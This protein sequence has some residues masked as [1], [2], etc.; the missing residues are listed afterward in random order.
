MLRQL[1]LGVLSIA[2]CLAAQNNYVVDAAGGGDFTDLPAALAVAVHGD[3]VQVRP[4]TYTPASTDQGIRILGSSGARFATGILRIHAL[5]RNRTFALQDFAIDANS[6]V[7]LVLDD[8]LGPVHLE[9]LRSTGNSTGAGGLTLTVNRSLAVT[10]VSSGFA[11]GAPGIKV[12]G[13]A[14]HL[15]LIDCVATGRS[16]LGTYPY[17]SGAAGMEIWGGR[18]HCT[19]CRFFGGWASSIRGSGGHG[20]SIRGTM[21]L[22]LGPGCSGLG[23]FGGDSFYGGSNGQALCRC[24]SGSGGL[25]RCDPSNT[26]LAGS[27]TIVATVPVVTAP[28][29]GPGRNLTPVWRGGLQRPSILV[30]SLAAPTTFLPWGPF[31]LDAAT[32]GVIYAGPA[33]ANP[34]AFPLLPSLPVGTV[35]T[36]QGLVDLGSELVL[37]NPRTMVL[38]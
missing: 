16:N 6:G 30:V 17:Y 27:A 15:T 5:P 20:I 36:L 12:T 24:S 7:G 9:N 33:I 11:V 34:P 32:S 25:I 10:A 19:D 35:I 3:I 23:G 29:T 18:V 13:S 28:P 37:T 31:H 22:Q 4:G 26:T 14:S 21:E 8:N 38:R 1:A 2:S